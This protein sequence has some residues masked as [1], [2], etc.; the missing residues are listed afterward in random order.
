[1]VAIMWWSGF[2]VTSAEPWSLAGNSGG[3]I[4]ADCWCYLGHS[5]PVTTHMPCRDTVHRDGSLSSLASLHA[6]KIFHITYN[7]GWFVLHD[8]SILAM[9]GSVWSGDL[10]TDPMERIPGY[11]NVNSDY[12]H[13][14]SW[15]SLCT[16][17]NYKAMLLRFGPC[18]LWL[19][20]WQVSPKVV[21]IWNQAM[22]EKESSDQSSIRP[23]CPDIMRSGGELVAVLIIPRSLAFHC[24]CAVTSRWEIMK[25]WRMLWRAEEKSAAYTAPVFA[26]KP[27]RLELE[28]REKLF[29][30]IVLQLP[31]RDTV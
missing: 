19:N 5:P 11:H 31:T 20:C 7:G 1:M 27:G 6:I 30:G 16:M 25:S 15:T 18:R 10:V 4:G 14:Q 12:P 3:R 8:C 17:H 24:N 28:W 9:L 2:Q 22:I 21:K 26:S 23:P 29:S 13:L